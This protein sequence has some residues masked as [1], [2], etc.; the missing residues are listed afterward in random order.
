MKYII[1]SCIF[2]LPQWAICQKEQLK[3]EFRA[4]WIAT[5]ANIDWPSQD[6]IS[7]KEQQSE[8]IDILQF[9]QSLNFNTVIV[10]VRAAGD[11]FYPSS[12][13]PWSKYLTGK[14]GTSPKP[15]YDP[16]QWMIE[17]SH[18]RGFEFHA[19]FNPYR[20]TFN[21]DT[22]SLANSHAFYQH[23]EWMIKYGKK[24]YFNPGLPEVRKY[25]TN[26]IM[27][28][29]NNYEIDGVH[30]DDYFYPYKIKDE[31]FEDSAAFKLNNNASLSLDDWRR[32]NVDSLVSNISDSIRAVKPW[33]QFGIS[34]FG[35]WRNAS[36]DP[37]GSDTQAGQTTYDDLYADPLKWDENQWIDYIVP[38]LYWSMDHP[39]ASHSK[40][41][42]WWSDQK[43]KSHLYIG[44]GTYKVKNNSDK[45]WNKYREIPKQIELTRGK[46]EVDGSV[47]FSAK[48]LI[49]KH[50][51]LVKMMAR[52]NY[53]Y[54]ALPMP[55][56]FISKEEPGQPI[57]EAQW[58]D[59]ERMSI[60]VKNVDKSIRYIMVYGS[61]DKDSVDLDAAESILIKISYPDS[62]EATISFQ[63]KQLKKIKQLGMTYINNYGQES[64][65]SVLSISKEEVTKKTD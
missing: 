16:L 1:L 3:H 22:A 51:R 50:K 45:A 43:L 28:V 18:E 63:K 2:Y 65:V 11:A 7:T 36:V 5:V 25:T 38:Q 62:G 23:P 39:L 64:S 4:I 47:F 59:E 33:V 31:I 20:A 42:N 35:V 30:F 12:Y 26:V 49:N 17:E 29:V 61:K 19:W 56:P 55:T 27:E 32:A 37:S 52:K 57:V 48:S 24:H 41:V 58:T 44:H 54:Q 60:T 34:P 9:Y 40:L 46:E 8:F 21:L 14:E 6:D 10:Q 13:E 15:Y 53:R